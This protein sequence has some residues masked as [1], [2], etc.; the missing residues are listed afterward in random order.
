MLA[1]ALFAALSVG[2]AAAST[3]ASFSA[4]DVTT[5]NGTSTTTV[6]INAQNPPPVLQAADIVLLVDDSGSIGSSVFNG[7]VRP[8]LSSFIA[9]ASPSGAGNHIGIME[10]STTARNVSAGLQTS[11][12]V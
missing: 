8:T 3:S 7:T 5:C 11:T 2:S 9:S 1:A 4:T 10:F 6:Q 12:A